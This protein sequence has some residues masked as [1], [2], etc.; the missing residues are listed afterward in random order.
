MGVTTAV[1]TMEQDVASN[2]GYF[3]YRLYKN[4]LNHL[5][6]AA[7]TDFSIEKE[8][9]FITDTQCH[10]ILTLRSGMLNFP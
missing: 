5:P 7:T 1:F 4:N 2:I 10:F 8:H 6:Q 9:R 3:L